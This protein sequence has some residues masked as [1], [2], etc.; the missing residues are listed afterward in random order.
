MMMMIMMNIMMLNIN[1]LNI[2]LIMSI[3]V[4]FTC[5]SAPRLQWWSG[6]CKFN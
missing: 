6:T 3:K 4:T 1:M 2:V 5:S